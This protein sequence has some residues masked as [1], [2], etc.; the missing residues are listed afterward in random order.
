MT[1]SRAG[2][3]IRPQGRPGQ[4]DR[5]RLAGRLQP[6]DEVAEPLRAADAGRVHVGGPGGPR[7]GQQRGVVAGQRR[8]RPRPGAGDGDHDP[9]GP[10]RDVG[11]AHVPQIRADQPGAGP[12][13]DQPGRARPPLAGGLGIGQREV[14]ADLRGGIR[15]LGPLPRQRQVRRV[16]LRDHPAADEPQVRAQRPPRRAGQ[17]RRAAGEPLGRRRVQQHLRNRLKAQPEAV[18]SELARRPEQ[19]LRPP[20]PGRPHR[21]D[22]VPG[23]RRRLSRHRRRAPPPDIGSCSRFR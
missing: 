7:C 4:P 20:L 22:H 13:A 3:A 23:E 5:V 11:A 21:Q 14:P 16:E 12:E 6:G 1:S 15:R 17:P 9:A 2:S 18:I 10:A 19:V 8:H